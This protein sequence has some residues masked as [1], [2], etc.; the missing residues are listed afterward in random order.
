MVRINLR[1]T[2]VGAYQ[3]WYGNQHLWLNSP[4]GDYLRWTCLC[5]GLRDEISRAGNCKIGARCFSHMSV[6]ILLVGRVDELFSL[7]VLQVSCLALVYW[8]IFVSTVLFFYTLQSYSYVVPVTMES[9]IKCTGSLND[10]GVVTSS[11]WLAACIVLMIRVLP[12]RQSRS[13]LMC[14]KC[15]NHAQ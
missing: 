11:T 6:L 14:N 12:S 3:P 9:V 15:N 7:C 1:H 10:K 4:G 2:R 13:L 8:Y 5:H